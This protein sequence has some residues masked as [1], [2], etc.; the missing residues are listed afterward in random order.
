M[1]KEEKKFWRDVDALKKSLG[2][3][4]KMLATV[5]KMQETIESMQVFV[6]RIPRGMM[7]ELMLVSSVEDSE[8]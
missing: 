6:N 4:P 3:Q 1:T 7:M 8:S 5:V 2:K